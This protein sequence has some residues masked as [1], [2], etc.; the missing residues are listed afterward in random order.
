M[1]SKSTVR[2]CCKP[3][4]Q[5]CQRSPWWQVLVRT[6]RNWNP[7]VSLVVTYNGR[8]AL[9]ISMVVC[10]KIK[11]R[12]TIWPS[13]CSLRRIPKRDENIY[14]DRQSDTTEQQQPT[15]NLY[16]SVCSSSITP[17]CQKVETAE[18]SICPW[19]N[20]MWCIHATEYSLAIKR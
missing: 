10:Y 16:L 5:L 8:S 14:P 17:N 6:W 15:Q 20:S 1:K 3:T 12:V 2:N 13:P 7:R 4:R 18:T 9:E 19:I 11:H